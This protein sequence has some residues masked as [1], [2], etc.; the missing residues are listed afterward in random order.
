MDYNGIMSHPQAMRYIAEF[1]HQTGLL[2]F[3][4]SE[5]FHELYRSLCTEAIAATTEGSLCVRDITV[6]TRCDAVVRSIETWDGRTAAY[7]RK[8]WANF[9]CSTLCCMCIWDRPNVFFHCGHGLCERDAWRYS[10]RQRPCECIAEFL[11]CPACGAK[12]HSKLRL[13]PLQAGYRVATFDGGGVMGIV[14]LISLETVIQKLPVRL[15]AH[16][17]FGLIVGSIIAAALGIQQWP[18]HRC[19][20]EF[21]TTAHQVFQKSTPLVSLY[22]VIRCLWTGVKHSGATLYQALHDVFD[23]RSLSSQSKTMPAD[24]RV[25][26]TATDSNGEGHLSRSYALAKPQDG[27]FPGRLLVGKNITLAIAESC[28]APLYF[29]PVEG[30]WDGGLVANNPSAVART[31]ARC[32]SGGEVPDY[33]ASFGTKRYHRINPG[34]PCSGVALD[35]A[36]AI[37]DLQRMTRKQ[38]TR[39]L[40]MQQRVSDL[41]LPML[42]CMF[43]P[44]IS[45]PPCFDPHAGLYDVTVVVVSRWED[46]VHTSRQLQDFLDGACFWVQGWRYRSITPLQVLVTLSGLEES[47]SIE[48]QLQGGRRHHINGLPR[49]VEKVLSDQYNPDVNM[50]QWKITGRKRRSSDPTSSPQERNSAKRARHCHL[51]H[52]IKLS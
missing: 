43:Y 29:P 24:I 37:P 5:V 14:S 40:K 26:I 39:D 31:E 10:V 49:T 38:M 4:T 7:V 6:N 3:R 51:P 25:A 20:D 33:A 19:I 50:P 52:A 12:I 30:R 41:C 15:Q 34:L 1:I 46:D 32:L 21:A 23:S 36:T 48:L 47:L 18:L 2:S 44:I 9:P 22:K 28:A 45:S 11:H 13:R 35:D 27:T 16:H 42:S 8:V 17:Y